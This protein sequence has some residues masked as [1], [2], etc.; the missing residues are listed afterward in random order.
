[1]TLKIASGLMALTLLGGCII[2]DADDDGFR[3]DFSTDRYEYGTVY[4]ADVSGSSVAFIVS[5]NGCTD[6]SFFDFDIL[7]DDGDVFEIGVRRVRQDHC[8]ALVPEGVEIGW[9]YS[10]MGLPDDAEVIVRN[11][12]RR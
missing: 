3:A 8:K 9:T 12:V 11:R 5:S 2:I 7:D 10:E 6:R 1:M 4:G